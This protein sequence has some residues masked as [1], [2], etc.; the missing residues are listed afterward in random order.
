MKLMKKVWS[1]IRK[2][3]KNLD[4]AVEKAI[5]VAT[6]IVEG[7]KTAVENDQVKYA[8]EIVKFAIPG[9]TDDKIIDK[10]MEL[11]QKY[12]PEIALKLKIINSIAGIEDTNEQMLAVVGAL[13]LANKDTKSDYWHEL[14]AQIL[15]ALSDNKITLGEAGVLVEYH[16]KNYIKNNNHGTT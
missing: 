16:Y 12:I 3:W 14:S 15:K 6:A 13:K 5:P 4:K 1:W 7:V 9:D 2:M 8:L 10:A 11:A